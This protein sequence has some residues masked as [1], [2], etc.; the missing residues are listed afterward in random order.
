MVCTFWESKRFTAA[1]QF[2]SGVRNFTV[3]NPSSASPVLVYFDSPG[4]QNSIVF[5]TAGFRGWAISNASVKNVAIAIDGIPYGTA[6][7]GA[8]RPDVCAAYANAAN[9]PNVGWAFPIDTTQFADGPHTVT[10]TATVPESSGTYIGAVSSTFTVVN[11]ST[12]NPMKLNFDSP[13][14]QSGPFSGSVSIGGWVIDT[15]APITQVSVAVDGI[16]LGN[17]NSGVLRNDVCAVFPGSIGCPNVGWNYLLNT[18]LFPDGT[19]TLAVTGMTAGGQNSTFTT[20]FTT[21]NGSSTPIHINIDT[22]NSSQILAGI[23]PIGGW[24][25]DT[26]GAAITSV[27]ILVDGETLGSG[28][29][30]GARADVCAHFTT[31]GGCPNVGWNYE[32]N[33]TG[34]ANGGHTLQVRATA[35]DGQQY[36]VS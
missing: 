21:A 14:A 2:V 13:N 23:S 29:Y 10:A 31:A 18:A 4:P 20:S 5:G 34:F 26:N 35:S 27:D 11:W 22:P 9:C 19:H 8:P 3:A 12:S 25:L 1:G 36:T 6:A 32:L 33:T 16:P 7:Y 24:A 30:G 17:A 15:Q 28:I